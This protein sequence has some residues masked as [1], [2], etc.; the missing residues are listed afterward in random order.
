MLYVCDEDSSK[1][2]KWNAASCLSNSTRKINVFAANLSCRHSQQLLEKLA[3]FLY[4][5]V[6]HEKNRG[7]KARRE[8]LNV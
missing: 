5:A 4:L 6:G 2:E 3:A 8:L 1:K 7:R